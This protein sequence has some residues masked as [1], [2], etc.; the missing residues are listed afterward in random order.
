MTTAYIALGSNLGDRAQTLSRAVVQLGRLGRVV[1]R[2]SVYETEPVGYQEQ[3]AFLN[4][5]VALETG[6][7][8]LD[9]LRALLRIEVEMGRD[10]SQGTPKGPRTLDLDLL[11]MGDRIVEDK[12]L[13]LPHPALTQRRFVMAPLAE[14]APQLRHPLGGQSIAELLAQLPEEGENRSAG[15]RRLF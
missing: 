12:E 2:S 5:V 14:I 6:L 13:T 3:P 15:V 8:P 4:A 9:L 1:A 7:E 11:L 10:R